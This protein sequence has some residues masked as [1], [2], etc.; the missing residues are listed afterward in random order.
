LAARGEGGRE[1][2]KEGGR[3]RA[4]L[5][6]G[7][8]DCT[9]R[10]WRVRG[11]G[12]SEGGREAAGSVENVTAALRGGGEG[13]RGGGGGEPVCPEPLHILRGH[14]EGVTAVAVSVALD[15]VLSGARDGTVLVHSLRD[16]RYIRTL[17]R[18]GG[19]EGGQGKGDSG[20]E[21]PPLL[22]LG[23][24]PVEE[25]EVEEEGKQALEGQLDKPKRRVRLPCFSSPHSPRTIHWVGISPAGYLLSY[26]RSS[27]LLTSHSLNGRLLAR[28]SSSPASLYAFTF[29]EDGNVVLLGGDNK[30]VLLLWCHSLRLASDGARRGLEGLAVTDG[31]CADL[32]V[33][34]FPATVRCLALTA[35]ER[36]LLVGLE[37]GQ[38][39][40]LAPEAEY[41]RTR[42]KVKLETMGF[43]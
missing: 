35:H 30:K 24:V 12:G 3:G 11:K 6:S 32:S 43:Y 14:A 39:Y 31:G 19:R 18:R 26:S 36:H 25:V 5:V 20:A 9:V 13:G 42:L 10:V 16:G 21:L 1:G 38:A 23:S 41:L 34:P 15:V 27:G 17:R 28:V 33:T 8:E 29:S 37:N 22:M 4:F 7:S 40:V 2:R